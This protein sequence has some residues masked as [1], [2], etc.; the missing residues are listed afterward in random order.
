[1]DSSNISDLINNIEN[2]TFADAEQVFNDIMDLK[3]G[4]HLDQMRRDMAANVFNDTP[5][6]ADEFD[7]Y[8]ITDEGDDEYGEPEE[9]E[10]EDEDL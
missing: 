2:G 5:D 10:D 4:E 7:H 6:E 9:I 8:E 1:M 3:A